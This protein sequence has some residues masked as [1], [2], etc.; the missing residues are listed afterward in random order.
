M[1]FR[2]A[3]HRLAAAAALAA[4]AVLAVPALTALTAPT[5][6][7]PAFGQSAEESEYA[8]CLKLLDHDAAAA[9]ESA[10][11]WQDISGGA[12]ARH[13]AA[14]ALV[15]LGQPAEAAT[16]LEALAADM[17]DARPW[18]RAGVLAQAGQAWLTADQPERAYAAFT[19]ALEITPEAPEI[20]IDRARRWPRR[21]PSGKRSTTLAR[22]SS[23]R[24]GGPMPTPSAPA[25]TATS[26]IWNS[27]STTPSARWRWRPMTRSRAWSAATSGA[28]RAT[29]PA[30]AP[31][32]SGCSRWRPAATPPTTRAPISNASTSR[33]TDPWYDPTAAPG[34]V[35]ISPPRR[36]SIH[37]V[38]VWLVCRADP[39]FDGAGVGRVR[40]S[41]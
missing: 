2:V 30:R 31:I 26:T 40:P 28:C 14:L 15:R 7:A 21:A 32:G 6:V 33:P 38:V 29:T 10:L 13:C 22:P 11:A 3:R 25:R 8:A 5:A 36:L 4:L 19:V 27:P 1:A 35:P 41:R 17:A 18:L 20:Y 23:W 12:P 9:F 24:P 37:K 16:R 39:K 34:T